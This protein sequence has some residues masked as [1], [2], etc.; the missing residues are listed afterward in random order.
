MKKTD[1]EWTGEII[2]GVGWAL[3]DAQVGESRPHQHVAHQVCL[4]LAGPV[5]IIG[6]DTREL[7]QGIAVVIP[8][9]FEHSLQPPG[10]ILRSL[11]VD[12]FFRGFRD[13]DGLTGLIALSAV[14]S[15]ALAAVRSGEEAQQWIETVFRRGGQTQIDH[16]LRS[17]ID[18]FEP[19]ASPTELAR[20]MQ[21]STTRLREISVR[22][23]GVPTTKLLQWLQVQKAIEAFELSHNL[24]QAASAGGFSDQA[25]FTRRLVEWF[26]VTRHAASPNSK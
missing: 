19:G 12:P 7:S 23:F 3:L 21:L 9:G 2:I 25:H 16:R 17:I 20:K 6:I 18:N 26:G 15:Q 14:E 8:A 24:A 13:L 1:T 11:Y 5:S 10:G 22:D 4:A